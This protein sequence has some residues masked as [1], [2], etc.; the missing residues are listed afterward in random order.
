MGCYRLSG[1]I[2]VKTKRGKAGRREAIGC[3]FV[4]FKEYGSLESLGFNFADSVRLL[5]DR[6][7]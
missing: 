3:Y 1:S 4:G 6:L 2:A 7:F 5:A